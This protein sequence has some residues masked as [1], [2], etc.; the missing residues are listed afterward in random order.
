MIKETTLVEVEKRI[1]EQGLDL[2]LERAHWS[3]RLES[4]T[5]ETKALNFQN[6]NIINALSEFE[7]ETL[8]GDLSNE[9]KEKAVP[10]GN[11]WYLIALSYQLDINFEAAILAFKQAIAIAPDSLYINECAS[12][13]LQLG[14]FNEAEAMF[15]LLVKQATEKKQFDYQANGWGGLGLVYS[16]QANYD[17]AADAFEKAY[18]SGKDSWDENQKT[19]VLLQSAQALEQSGKVNESLKKYDEIETLVST[20]TDQ[21]TTL[22]V[23]MHLGE[24]YSGAARREKAIENYE[25]GLALSKESSRLSY[26]Q[27]FEAGLGMVYESLHDHTKALTHLEQ[28]FIAAKELNDKEAMGY[29]VYYIALVNEHLGEKIQAKR[30]FQ[31]AKS[32]LTPLLEK[33]HPFIIRVSDHLNSL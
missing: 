11:I 31:E 7:F 6:P 33:E 19:M 8:R 24:F 2:I 18:V 29:A 32:L 23:L 17:S 10:T 15:K 12:M 25:K 1:Q 16:I 27:R 20:V 21:E 5:R 9:I 30:L 28:A 22:T 14:Q 13:H 3:Q 4:L 26:I